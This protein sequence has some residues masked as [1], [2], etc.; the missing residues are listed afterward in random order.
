MLLFDDWYHYR[1]D[2]N[3]GEQR[4]FREWQAATEAWTIPR[5]SGVSNGCPGKA[6][7]EKLMVAAQKTCAPEQPVHHEAG[8]IT[9]EKVFNS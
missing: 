9:P 1:G 4:A 2:P 5:C 7:P 6:G 8:V 3:A